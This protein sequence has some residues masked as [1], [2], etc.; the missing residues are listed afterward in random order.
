MNNYFFDQ[1]EKTFE[2]FNL[3]NYT[4][5]KIAQLLIRKNFT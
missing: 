5:L 1:K 3:Q 2:T 4:Y